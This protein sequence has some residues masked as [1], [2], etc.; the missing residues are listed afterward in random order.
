MGG[1]AFGLGKILGPNIGEYQG[2]ELGVGGLRSRGR[3]E[4]IGD[5]WRGN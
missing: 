1:E 5:F 3:G 4:G 2:Q